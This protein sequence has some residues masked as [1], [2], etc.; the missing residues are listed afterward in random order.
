MNCFQARRD[1]L[2]SPRTRSDERDAHLATCTECAAVAERVDAL[3]RRIGEA[4]LVPVPEGLAHRVLL[5]RSG[6]PKRRLSSIAAIL[7]AAVA[8]A[9][10][11]PSA[12]DAFDLA[13]TAEVV[14]P[15]HPGVAAISLVAGEQRDAADAHIT[16][17]AAEIEQRLKRLG[18]TLGKG[19][20]TTYYVGKCRMAGG[21]CDHIVLNTPEGSADVLLLPEYAVPRRELVTDRHMTALVTPAPNGGYIVVAQSPKVVKRTGR[22]F[23]RG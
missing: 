19:D 21:E 20:A 17:D 13:G 8:T 6:G 15:A 14:G 4:A 12:M 23:R 11:F 18:L 2:T 5:A 1:L 10:V 9:L 7:T 16:G 22:L 3:D